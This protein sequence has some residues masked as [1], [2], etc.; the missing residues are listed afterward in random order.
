MESRATLGTNVPKNAGNV[1][2]RE[3]QTLL[4]ERT[5][6]STSNVELLKLAVKEEENEGGEADN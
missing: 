4:L 5:V 6:L 3:F 1:G 2:K